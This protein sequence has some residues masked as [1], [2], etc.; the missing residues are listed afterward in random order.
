MTRVS[1]TAIVASIKALAWKSVAPALAD[2]PELLEYRGTK[3]ENLLH[4]CCGIDIRKRSLRPADSVKMAQVLLDA[5]LDI[6]QEAFREGEWK[7]TPLWFAIGRGKNLKLADFLLKRGADPEYCMWAAAFNDDA[8]AIWLL[9]AA[10][11]SIDPKGEET[12][13]LFAVKWSRFSAAKAL[14]ELGA[15]ANAQDGKGKTALH[16]MRK[17]RSDPKYVRMFLRHGAQLV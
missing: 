7:A 11:A 4:V 8:G 12:P 13:L 1:K 10:G 5:R 9:H 6:D 2:N 15:D 16:Y 17:K 3:G 14:L